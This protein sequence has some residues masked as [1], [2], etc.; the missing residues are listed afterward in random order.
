ML[1]VVTWQC[2]CGMN[3]KTMYETDGVTKVRCPNS[4]C[5]ITRAVDGKITEL[6]IKG[7]SAPTEW[8]RHEVAGLIVR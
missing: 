2:L 4:F 8:Q 7:D 5:Q 3:V 6:W 1:A